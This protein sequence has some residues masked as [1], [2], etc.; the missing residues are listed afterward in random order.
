VLQYIIIGVGLIALTVVLHAIVTVGWVR[1]LTGKF[2]DAHGNWR[3]RRVLVVLT[4]T[5]IVLIVLHSVEI[6][7][8][9]LAYRWILPGPELPDFES[10]LYFSFVTFTTLGYGDITLSEGWRLL[11]GIEALNGLLLVGWT[12]ALLFAIVQRGWEGLA[13]SSSAT[14]TT[15]ESTGVPPQ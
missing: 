13:R 11:S 5:V 2:A 15:T 10:A 4:T 3:P 9:A 1:V 12:T 7:L 6:T 8:W 14:R